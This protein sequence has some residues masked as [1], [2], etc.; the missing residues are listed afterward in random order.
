MNYREKTNLPGKRG[1]KCVSRVS[2]DNRTLCS[3]GFMYVMQHINLGC[4]IKKR[5]GWG[6][7]QGRRSELENHDH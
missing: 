5:A 4:E 7:Q 6:K 3:I 2:R 1:G